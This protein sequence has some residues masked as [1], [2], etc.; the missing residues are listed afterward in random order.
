M[1]LPQLW[2]FGKRSSH[3]FHIA[4]GGKETLGTSK[5]INAP[6]WSLDH[7]FSIHYFYRQYILSSFIFLISSYLFIL[8]SQVFFLYMSTVLGYAYSTITINK[9]FYLSR[10]QISLASNIKAPDTPYLSPWISGVPAICRCE[11]FFHRKVT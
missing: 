3:A 6:Q 2:E 4:F 9:T 5:I 8:L 11:K 7:S 1:T 10:K